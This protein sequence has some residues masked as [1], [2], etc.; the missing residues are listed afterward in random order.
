MYVGSGMREDI[1]KID[2]RERHLVYRFGRQIAQFETS[3]CG[4]FKVEKKDETSKEPCGKT[5]PES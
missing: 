3:S 5:D 1:I 4:Q 2:D